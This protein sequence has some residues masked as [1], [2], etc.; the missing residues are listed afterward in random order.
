MDFNATNGLTNINTS[1]ISMDPI[2]ITAPSIGHNFLVG[3]SSGVVESPFTTEMTNIDPT[4]TPGGLSLTTLDNHNQKA[5]NS[6]GL[7]ESNHGAPYRYAMMGTDPPGLT[8]LK[9][10]YNSIADDTFDGTQGISH[11][12]N[13]LINK[14]TMDELKSK[15]D[16]FCK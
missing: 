12:L 7:M 5:M 6:C 9:S 15:I 1:S 14:Y 8:S 10:L 3:I 4:Y 16:E 11:P 13:P 2:P